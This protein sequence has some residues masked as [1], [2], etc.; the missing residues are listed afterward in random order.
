M[1][2]NTKLFELFKLVMSQKSKFN[3]HSVQM[4]ILVMEN[5]P[6]FWGKWNVS[7]QGGLSLFPP[8]TVH[9]HRICSQGIVPFYQCRTSGMHDKKYCKL[10]YLSC[11]CTY[12]CMPHCQLCP[13]R[14]NDP[15]CI[16]VWAGSPQ[17][18]VPVSSSLDLAVERPL[19]TKESRKLLSL[20]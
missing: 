11:R 19:Q 3:V 17:V 7:W 20:R 10:N 1:R 9:A 5:Y 14:L 13:W 4:K 2:R 15:G 18:K 8:A 16:G 12:T 6:C